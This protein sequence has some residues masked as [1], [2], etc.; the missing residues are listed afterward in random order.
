[1]NFSKPNRLPPACIATFA[2][3]ITLASL[4]HALDLGDFSVNGYYKNY[5]VAINEPEIDDPWFQGIVH[6]M[7]GAVSNRLRLDLRG[8]LKDWLSFNTAYDFSPRIQDRSLFYYNSISVGLI[9]SDYRAFDLRPRLYPGEGE[10]AA[11]FAIFQNLDRAFLSFRTNFADFYLGRQPIAW[12][13]ARVVNP[14]DV[15][16]PY[17]FDELDVEDR[18]GVDAIRMRLPIGFMGEVDAGYVFG[19]DFKSENNAMFLR[20]KLYYRGNDISLI[21]CGFRE[22][23]LLGFDLARSLGGAGF[24]LETG[25]VVVGALDSADEPDD[26]DYFRLSI[27]SDYSLRDGTYLFAEY[28]YNQ[29]GASNPDEYLL[30][31]TQTAYREGAVYL[32]GEHYLAPGVSYQ[33]TPLI[34]ATGQVLLSLTDQSV[35]TLPRIEYNIAENIYLSAGANLGFGNG[36]YIQHVSEFIEIIKLQSEFGSYSDSYFTSFR[37]YF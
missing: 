31:V 19:D 14:T 1:M 27:G 2:A 29:A 3:I 17:A 18:R 25:Y 34:F 30:G 15:L 35:F 6:P 10:R 12:G 13:S 20:T 11:S 24:W 37:I 36:P 7:I 5:S 32:M 8:R 33:I 28:H 22:N 16:A 26:Q 21:L 23:L 4:S 9:Q